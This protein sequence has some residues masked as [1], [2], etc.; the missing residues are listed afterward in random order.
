MIQDG[1]LRSILSSIRDEIDDSSAM[2]GFG[3]KDNCVD[4]ALRGRI[5]RH[6][7]TLE[8]K[9]DRLDFYGIRSRD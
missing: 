5:I 9:G 6:P 1:I 3:H 8:Q 2:E 7:P 4:V